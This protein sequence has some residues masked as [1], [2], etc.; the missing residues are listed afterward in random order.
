MSHSD[1]FKAL[2]ID[3][4]DRFA[5]ERFADASGVPADRLQHYDVSN[6]L[7]SGRDL[8][9]ICTLTGLSPVELM[10]KLGVLDRR[11]LKALKS[12]AREVFNLIRGDIEQPRNHAT[13]PPVVFKTNFGRLYQGNCLTLMNSMESDSIDL[14]F[15]D[16]PFNLKKLYPSG[17]NDDLNN[18]QYLEWCESW[19]AECVRLLKPGGSLFLWNIPKWNTHIAAYLNARLTFRHWIAVTIKYSLPISGRLYPSHYSLLYYCKSEKPRKFHPDR[20]P[21]EICPVCRA[22]LRDYGG[23]KDKM[24]PKGVNL[25]D[26]WT[27]IA[28]VRHSKYKRHRAS[29]ELPV[30]LMDRI[31]E[32]ASDEGDLIFDPFGGSGTTYVVAEIKRRRWIGIELGPI[33]DI[34]GRFKEISADADLLERIRR[35][36][37]CLFTEGDLSV[38]RQLGLWTCESMSRSASKRR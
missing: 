11:I 26:V 30:K 35:N 10:L 36:Y 24:N 31:I 25:T 22:D 27:D 18:T 7:P 4:R 14:V 23:Y 21:M 20:L 33:E 17:V 2:G 15:A 12:N 37:N 1:F 34:M 28:P 9:R 8:D 6:T 29:N 3:G 16:P 19:A 32:M 38:R 5:V 13:L